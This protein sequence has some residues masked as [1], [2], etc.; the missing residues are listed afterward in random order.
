V[1][2][3][4]VVLGDIKLEDWNSSPSSLSVIGDSVFW[5]TRGDELRRRTM[6]KPADPSVLVGKLPGAGSRIRG[7]K[8]GSDYAVM[9]STS[10][11]GIPR[12]AITFLS[13]GTL[14]VV[15]EGWSIACGKERVTILSPSSFASCG[16]DGCEN[17][18]IEGGDKTARRTVLDGTVVEVTTESGML[19]IKWIR[20]NMELASALYDGHL[21]GRD[22]LVKSRLGAVRMT[23]GR[24]YAVL[25]ISGD[26]KIHFAR[27]DDRGGVAA[28][29]VAE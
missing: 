8:V 26:E 1:D 19:R 29:K 20:D 10:A 21:K 22:V 13:K 2:A 3:G 6:S 24:D 28:V 25:A 15:D 27:L 7:C 16:T 23:T 4:K 11:D 17:K 5:V 9:L 18:T 12:L 14:Q